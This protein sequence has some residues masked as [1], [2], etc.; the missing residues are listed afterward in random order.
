MNRRQ[1]LKLGLS[2]G[3]A[4]TCPAWARVPERS[5][6]L[7]NLHTGERLRTVYWFNGRYLSA[8]L[9]KLNYLLRDHRREEIFPID[10]RLFDLLYFLTLKLEAN[11]PIEVI[12]G[13]RSPATNAM[14]V[15]HSSQV[16]PNSLHTCGMA[17][18]IRIP[19]RELK[20]VHQAALTLRAGGVGYYPVSNFVHV[21]VGRVRSWIGS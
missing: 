7:F 17:V 14:L 18:D 15:A 9:A 20:D 21:D 10:A 19:G 16:A 8:S 1:F 13:Y 12:S 11:K 3:I 4:F 6:T 2:A 5:L